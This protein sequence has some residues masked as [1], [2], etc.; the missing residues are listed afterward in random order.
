MRFYVSS[1]S[2]H[3]ESDQ[4]TVVVP[5]LMERRLS[6]IQYVDDI[7]VFIDHNL[8]RACNVK[9]LLA[10]FEQL[11]NFK[12]NFH[13]NK[14]FCL[15]VAK[16][17]EQNYSHLFGC[18]IG[19]LP[20]KYLGIPMTHRRLRNSEW[21][22][23]IDRFEKRLSSWKSKLLSSGGRLVLINSVLSSLPIFMM[24]FFEV[25]AG[26]L[27]K[28]DAIRSRFYWQ[29]GHSKKKYRLTKW[30]IICQPR[31]IGGLGVANLAI[32]NVCLLS[33]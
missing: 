28:L 12:I 14:L 18:G 6:I 8:E 27:Q 32:K 30:K 31:E 21:Q 4:F 3:K 17:Y 15:G 9:L 1:V 16:D 24:S 26:V 20:F 19:S 2:T 7:V 33:K 23:V 11:S 13:K 29:G 5:Y 25:P 10:A 22:S